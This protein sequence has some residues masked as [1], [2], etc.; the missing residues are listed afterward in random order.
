L[1][2]VVHHLA[3]D[4]VSWRI[5]L[6]D[7]ESAYDC[8]SREQ[9]IALPAK[10]TPFQQWADRL[11]EQARSSSVSGS[12]A[13]WQALVAPPAER[14]PLQATDTLERD[15]VTLTVEL[16]A[17]ETAALLQDVPP[18]YR[19]QINDVLLTALA[20]ALQQ[21]TGGSSF[22]IE[23]EG[24]GREDFASDLDVSR[25]VGWFTTLF[26]A[27][28]ELTRNMGTEA[29]LKS[30]KEQLRQLPHR[31]LSYGLLRYLR[32]D[33]SR[34]AL[35]VAE[36]PQ[37]LFN[38]L[39]Q[40]DQITAGSRLFAF[41]AEPTGPWHAPSGHRTHPVE[42]LAQVRDGRLR[43]DWIT[44]EQQIPRAAVRQL[45]SDFM[46]ALRTIIAHCKQL[47]AG[48]RTPA[49]FQLAT[50]RQSEIDALWQRYVGFED[51]YPLTPMQRLFYVMEQA[52]T[53]VGLEQWQFRVNGE[54]DSR[55]LRL[56]FEQVIARHPILRTAFVTPG[57]GEPIQVVVPAA[58]LP[59]QEKDWRG[60]DDA[61]R[62]LALD[63]ELDQDV[64]TAFDLICPPLLR[65]TLLRLAEAEWRLLWTTHH[66]CIDGWSWPRV[67]KEIASIYA[68]L[69]EQRPPAF[70]PAPGF[71]TY[72]A[73]LKKDTSASEAFWKESLAGLAAPTPLSLGPV[74]TPARGPRT[75][76]EPVELETNLSRA[77]TESF[78][79]LAR[80]H[81]MTL[82]TL[83]QG[84]WALLLAHYSASN[85][86]LFGASFSGRPAEV[87]GVET[88]IGPCVTNVPV[89]ATFTPDEAVV[90]WLAR[91][92]RQQ[93]DL[94]QH[95]YTPI[96]VIQSLSSIPWHSRLFHS[97]VVIQ[98]YQ[99]DAAAGRLGRH[100][101]IAPVKVPE[102]T[103][104]ALTLVFT[105]ADKLKIKLIYHPNQVQHATVETIRTDLP[106][107]LKALGNSPPGAN[108]GDVLAMLPKQTRG[109]AAAALEAAP[110][111]VAPNVPTAAPRGDAERR[112]AAIWRQLLGEKPIGIDDNFFD[113]GGQSIHIVRAH[114]LIEEAFGRS[115][116][117]VALLQF[118]TIRALAGQLAAAP[119]GPGEAH[120]PADAVAA[121][122]RK[123]REALARQRNRE[124]P[125]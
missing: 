82:G 48:G 93:L 57:E 76:T 102:A 42:I 41:A 98:N 33:A 89:R 54:L 115:L 30:V 110:P 49:D 106:A 84:G 109:K 107:V 101:Q 59:W 16:T 35:A 19:T 36:R 5:L 18:A 95:Q 4:G 123:Q 9:P 21:S 52:G 77:A 121:R 7:I 47:G 39:G 112:L 125:G 114:R 90:S 38:Y 70:E 80:A 20:Q 85:D 86:V 105:P 32:D 67:F 122:A 117:V 15:A 25:T 92:Q 72:V 81:Q 124:R 34:A 103:N 94:H 26:P 50:L 46:A 69:E 63:G 8:L 14:L 111:A 87:D 29:A 78:K 79:A 24:H 71:R 22:L 10:T 40:F 23:M 65:V 11:V 61:A 119:S 108:V 74:D 12:L 44:C 97:L 88:L 60:L 116:P 62:A 64:R 28:L 104:Y 120:K 53:G 1:F 58:T 99:V 96:D 43:A 27:R 113:I 68:A 56:A 13:A 55:L 83:V 6:E 3:V 2:L 37:V 100:V 45:A 75:S 66:L 118:P 31:G 51:A 91:L 17:E 73:W